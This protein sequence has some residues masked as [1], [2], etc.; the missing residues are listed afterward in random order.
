MSTIGEGVSTYFNIIIK[1][2]AEQ[3]DQCQGQDRWD[4]AVIYEENIRSK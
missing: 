2:H 1:L 3:A 4:K